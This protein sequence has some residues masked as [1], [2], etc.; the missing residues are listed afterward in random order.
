LEHPESKGNK[1][2]KKFFKPDRHWKHKP[3]T[4]GAGK[5]MD[6]DWYANYMLQ[7]QIYPYYCTVRDANPH[8]EVFLIEDNVHLHQAARSKMEQE[9][10]NLNI[11]FAPHS[12]YSPDL[13]PIEHCFGRLKGFLNDYEVVGASKKAKEDAETYTKWVW[14]E[15]DEMNAYMAKKASTT[16]F[17]MKALTC[18]AH[19]GN[20]NWTG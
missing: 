14:Q 2:L 20:N 3:F 6:A 10:A 7:A 5:G 9:A 12:P 17:M 8:S 4:K 19:G 1:G 16:T 18:I 15:D 13:H 11:K